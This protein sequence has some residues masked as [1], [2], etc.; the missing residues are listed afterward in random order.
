M[1]GLGS[2]SDVGVVG[3]GVNLQLLSHRSTELGLGQHAFDRQL[4]HPLGTFGEHLQRGHLAET[5]G[6]SSV[7][8]VDLLLRLIAFQ[9][10]LAGIN[11]DYM[12]SN[13]HE[14]RPLRTALASQD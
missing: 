14:W 4:D 10:G 3:V 1:I 11:D 9:H 7:M 12:V 5:S 8:S 6:I 13:V 2:L